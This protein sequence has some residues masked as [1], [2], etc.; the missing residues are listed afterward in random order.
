MDNFFIGFI[1]SFFVILGLVIVFIIPYFRLRSVSI[2]Y[3]K[4]LQ[5]KIEELDK[6]VNIIPDDDTQKLLDEAEGLLNKHEH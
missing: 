6:P 4:T 1:V 5:K 3:E 2:R